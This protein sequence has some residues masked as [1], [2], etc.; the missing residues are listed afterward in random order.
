MV[1][2]VLGAVAEMERSLIIERVKA[3]LRK[4]RATGTRSGQAIGSPRSEV[5]TEEI[6]ARRAAGESVQQVADSL[7]ISRGLVYKRMKAQ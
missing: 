5:S 1:F 3:G 4:A 7:G 6:M 2:T